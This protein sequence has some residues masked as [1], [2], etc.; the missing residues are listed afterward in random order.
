MKFKK[1]VV[2]GARGFLG[3]HA[4]PV[5]EQRYGTEAVTALSRDHYD[6]EQPEQVRRLFEEQR[7]DAVVHLAAYVGGIGANR[8]FPATFFYRNTMLTA[9]MFEEAARYGLPKLLYPM[10]GCSYPAKAR[11]PIDES[12]MWEGYPQPESAPYSSAKKMALVA[13]SA[14]RRQRGLSSV[15]IIPGNM[16]GEYDN[17]RNAESHV[18]PALVRK[19]YEAR[20]AGTPYIDAWG[21]GR[22]TRDFVYAGDVARLLPFFLE[23][24]DSDEP[25]NL[26]SGTSTSIRELV[27][28]IKELTGFPG[29]IRWDASKP[30]GQMEKIFDVTR[31]HAL[32]LR[33]DTPLRE[34]LS[35]TIDWLNRH[36]AAQSDGLR[37]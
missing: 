4:V 7:P 16:Y 9:L 30:D 13:S 37:L 3:R 24:Y 10:G 22:P 26:S 34:G 11:S 21:T 17:F 23:D 15:V 2:T 19:Y 25:V 12:Q 18:V 31:M 20:L 35:R 5:L 36:Y 28:T 1:I 29:E 33:C 32:G 6:L 14:Y 27:E 8:E